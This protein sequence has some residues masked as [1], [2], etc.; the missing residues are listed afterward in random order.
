M[1][2]ELR[3]LRNRG[4]QF[5]LIVLDPPKFAPTAAHAQKQGRD[6]IHAAL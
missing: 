1:F 4:E 6:G 3:A 2:S 5:G